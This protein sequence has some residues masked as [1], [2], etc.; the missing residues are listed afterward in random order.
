MGKSVK[1]AGLDKALTDL[2][3]SIGI[4]DDELKKAMEDDEAA[5][6]GEDGGEA[7][8]E[9]ESE[10]KTPPK[11]TEKAPPKKEPEEDE[12]EDGE[13]GGEEDG[14]DGGEGEGDA[15]PEGDDEDGEKSLAADYDLAKSFMSDENIEAA[16]DVGPFLEGLVTQ[17][18]DS[19]DKLDRREVR[20]QKLTKSIAKAEFA[21]LAELA[22][23]LKGIVR[24]VNSQGDLLNKISGTPMVQ[25]SL[26][27]RAVAVERQLG[28]PAPGAAASSG[29]AQQGDIIAKSLADPT[30]TFDV[31]SFTN[32]LYED[33]AKSNGTQRGDMVGMLLTQIDTRTVDPELVKSLGYSLDV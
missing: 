19:L 9:E 16:V 6:A 15:P 27:G 23:T 2:A 30:K 11:K 4:E 29:G 10:K 12:G 17:V 32:A 7:G 20:S 22:K 3:K 13:D 28:N 14:E 26:T 21:V 24:T 5:A 33:L 31:Q 1:T 18:A 8:S 25:K